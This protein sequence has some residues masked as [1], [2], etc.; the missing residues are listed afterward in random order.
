MINPRAAAHIASLWYVGKGSSLYSFASCGAI[1]D[2]VIGSV[3]KEI[4]EQLEFYTGYGEKEYVQNLKELTR[5]LEFLVTVGE[6]GPQDGWYEAVVAQ[7]R[8]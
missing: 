5:L 4:I 3:K 6:R 7:G 1:D 2:S 8:G